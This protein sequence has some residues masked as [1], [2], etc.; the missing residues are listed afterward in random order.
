MT[1]MGV[2]AMNA[3]MI[4]MM[5]INEIEYNQVNTRCDKFRILFARGF[6]VL[7]VVVYVVVALFNTDPPR[8]DSVNI[9]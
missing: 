1:S 2:T 7:G 3:N 8:C 6:E 9:V 5:M 4:I